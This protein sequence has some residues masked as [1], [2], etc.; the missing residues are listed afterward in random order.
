MDKTTGLKMVDLGCGLG[1]GQD[2]WPQ[3]SKFQ[4]WVRL[5]ID[6]TTA[7][8]IYH[9]LLRYSWDLRCSQKNLTCDERERE[10]DGDRNGSI[11]YTKLL[12]TCDTL[13]AP[14]TLMKIK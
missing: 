5:Q 11:M 8:V 6:K 10:R 9:T 13:L 4:M 12:Y 1:D 2:H 3:N 14:T 7:S